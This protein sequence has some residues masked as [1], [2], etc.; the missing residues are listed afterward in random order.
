MV[1]GSPSRSDPFRAITVASSLPAAARLPLHSSV[2]GSVA[3][4]AGRGQGEEAGSLPQQ[5]PAQR[6]GE[7]KPSS[8][9]WAGTAPVPVPRSP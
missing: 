3:A 5:L 7:E 6:R 9:D 1:K 8:E 4:E 2:P